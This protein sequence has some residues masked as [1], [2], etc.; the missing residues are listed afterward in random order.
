MKRLAMIFC[1]LAAVPAWGQDA[2]GKWD[3]S[4][5]TTQRPDRRTTSMVLKKEGD[6]LS[7]TLIGPQNAE[8]AVTGTQSG[9]DIAL[10]FKVPTQDGVFEVSMKGRQD[11]ESMKGTLEVGTGVDRGDWTAVR[12]AGTGTTDSSAIDLTGTWALEVDTEFG[13][14]TPSV[15]LKQEGGKLTGRYHSQ[16]GEV[17]V[18]GQVKEKTFTFQVTL[19]FEGNPVTITYTGTVDRS[20]VKGQL[21]FGDAAAGTFTGKKQEGGRR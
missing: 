11:G 17:P 21:T 14:R 1:V 5:T 10:S 8:L 9:P 6:K 2:S 16:L 13:K 15:T 18:T 19:T 7:G 20:I 12:S 3:L 4:V